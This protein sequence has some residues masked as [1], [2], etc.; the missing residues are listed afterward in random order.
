MH[1]FLI[2]FVREKITNHIGLIQSIKDK[3]R[4]ITDPFMTCTRFGCLWPILNLNLP[5]PN[6]L[7]GLCIWMI[8]ICIV[9]HHIW[10]QHRYQIYMDESNAVIV[11]WFGL[12][13]IDL[14]WAHDS[15]H[16]IY[17]LSIL[18]LFWNIIDIVYIWLVVII[19]NL[20]VNFSWPFL[21]EDANLV[22]FLEVRLIFQ[23]AS[24]FNCET[25]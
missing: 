17:Q 5:D 21:K 7:L 4:V 8:N 14:D 24:S 25:K 18:Y 19:Y 12:S 22:N 13:H 20:F 9:Y 2:Y 3:I 11:N 6:R 1:K 15:I 23:A 16:T 10:R